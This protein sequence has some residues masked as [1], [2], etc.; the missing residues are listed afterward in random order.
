MEKY[1]ELAKKLNMVDA[2]IITPDHIVFDIRSLLK[3]KW[4]C[5]RSKK[6]TIKCDTRGTKYQ[7]RVEMIKKYKSILLL[8][9]HK[10]EFLCGHVLYCS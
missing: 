3:C 4:G 5:E 7:E 2:L 6:E 10:D 9:S 8:H 1:V